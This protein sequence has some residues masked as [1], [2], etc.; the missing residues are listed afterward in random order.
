[1]ANV[2]LPNLEIDGMNVESIWKGGSNPRVKPL[3]WFYYNAL[4]QQRAAMR[5]GKWKLIAKFDGGKLP[6]FD[7]IT[8]ANIQQIRSAKLTDFS[9]Y[10]LEN[11]LGEQIDLA[12][13]HTE[14]LS[15]LSQKMQS[16]YS[17]LVHSMHIWPEP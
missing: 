13:T 15:E 9:L 4:N 17:E 6:K 3:F 16:I 12:Q 8:T 5:D 2:S 14:L 10:D 11:D 7:N 1:L